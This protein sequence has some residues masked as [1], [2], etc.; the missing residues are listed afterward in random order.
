MA[1][2]KFEKLRQPIKADPKR[3]RRAERARQ[4]AVREL[5]EHNL[6]EVR[7]ARQ[8]TQEEIARQLGI[9]Q[10]G[11][12]RIENQDDALLSTLRDYVEALGGQLEVVAVFDGERIPIAS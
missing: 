3:N 11:V 4:E 1:T 5:V 7:K 9:A 6:A 12:S 2:H 10:S 8:I